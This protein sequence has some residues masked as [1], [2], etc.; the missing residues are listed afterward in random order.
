MVSLSMTMKIKW[1]LWRFRCSA[2]VGSLCHDSFGYMAKS[3]L[4]GK[5]ELR[6]AVPID[7]ILHIFKYLN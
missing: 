3:R 4:A 7:N 2:N 1:V 6:W 5:L